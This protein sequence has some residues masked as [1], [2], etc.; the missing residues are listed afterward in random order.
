MLAD[1]QTI[2]LTGSGSRL[3]FLGSTS[4]GPITGDGTLHYEDGTTSEYTVTLDD[5]FNPPR[6]GNEVVSTMSYINTTNPA[7]ADDG[8]GGRRTEEVYVFSVAVPLQQGKALAGVTLPDVA[9]T[10]DGGRP[11]FHVFALGVG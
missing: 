8:V 1:G 7:R 4:R 11:G 9:D 3:G 2:A 5:Y 10:V 6:S